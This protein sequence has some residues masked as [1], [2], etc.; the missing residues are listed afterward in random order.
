MNFEIIV[1]INDILVLN[2]IYEKR[3]LDP[4]WNLYICTVPYAYFSMKA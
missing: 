4:P 3:I 1:K 2:P